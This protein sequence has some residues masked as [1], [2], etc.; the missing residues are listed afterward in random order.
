MWLPLKVLVSWLALGKVN[1][2]YLIQLRRV[3]CSRYGAAGKLMKTHPWLREIYQKLT[4]LVGNIKNTPLIEGTIKNLTLFERKYETSSLI[5]GEK[6]PFDWEKIQMIIIELYSCI[7]IGAIIE[8]KAD[9]IV[10]KTW[11]GAL[12]FFALLLPHPPWPRLS[13]MFLFGNLLQASDVVTRA[14]LEEKPNI[15]HREEQ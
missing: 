1:V 15:F 6:S 5:E 11:Y 7:V 9:F 2:V 10:K 3:A 8:K 12:L 4:L 13:T 14:S